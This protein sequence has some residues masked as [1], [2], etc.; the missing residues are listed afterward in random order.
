M[1]LREALIQ[2]WVEL[3]MSRETAEL[4][5]KISD[6]FIPDAAPHTH[7][8]VKPGLERQFIEEMKQIFRKMDANREAVQAAV[9]KEMAKRN[10]V[11]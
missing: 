10:K 11:N 4:R 5:A 6:A 1:T 9:R 8:P 7:S 3:G 2:A